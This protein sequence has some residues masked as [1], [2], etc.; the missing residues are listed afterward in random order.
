[1]AIP[2]LY[3]MLECTGCGSR[4]VVH[5][6]YLQFVGTSDPDPQEG[7]GYEGPPLGERYTCAKDCSQPM[8]PIGSIVD[9]DDENMWLHEPHAPVRITSAQADEWKQWI[10]AAGLPAGGTARRVRRKAWWRVW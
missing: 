9:P 2:V 7:E 5:D 10:H 8:K 3:W 4:R 6:S 1:M